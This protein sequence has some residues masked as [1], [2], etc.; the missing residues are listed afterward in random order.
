MKN[1][2]SLT[3]RKLTVIKKKSMKRLAFNFA[4][5]DSKPTSDELQSKRASDSNE[6]IVASLSQ[7]FFRICYRGESYVHK[8][9][10]PDGDIVYVKIKV[11]IFVD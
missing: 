8:T 6:S 7:M 4:S 5:I 3:E 9:G 10:I 1:K 2:A 11:V